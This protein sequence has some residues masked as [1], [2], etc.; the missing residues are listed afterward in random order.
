MG[1]DFS[2]HIFLIMDS[3]TEC[4]HTGTMWILKFTFLHVFEVS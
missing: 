1:Q 2:F 4:E 3:L